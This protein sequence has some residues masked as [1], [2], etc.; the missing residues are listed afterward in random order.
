MNWKVQ[1]MI[2]SQALNGLLVASAMIPLL[3]WQTQITEITRAKVEAEVKRTIC[4]SFAEVGYLGFSASKDTAETIAG[5]RKYNA[6]YG[7]FKCGATK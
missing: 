4:A 5:I 3:F 1:P 2:L 7:S 6:V